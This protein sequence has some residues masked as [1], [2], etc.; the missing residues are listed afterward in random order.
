MP[1]QQ[2]VFL[3][4]SKCVHNPGAQSDPG[5]EVH[6]NTSHA[7]ARGRGEDCPVVTLI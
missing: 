3:S 2:D 6:H 1:R 4:P 5:P 7:D